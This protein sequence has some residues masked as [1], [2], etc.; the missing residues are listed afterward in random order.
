MRDLRPRS[1][2]Q[3]RRRGRCALKWDKAPCR[4]CGT[5]CGVMVGVQGQPGGRHPRRHQAEVN[6]GLNCVKGYFLSKIMYGARPAHQPLLRKKN[7]KYD[8]N[9]EFTPVSWD[10]AFDV[11]AEK[12]KAA[13]KKRADGGR[14]VR[15]RPVDDLGRLCRLEADARPAS[16]PTTSIPTR[17]TAWPRPSPA[18][19][20]PS[21]WT[22]RWAATTTSRPPTPSCCGARTWPRC[23]RSCGRASPTAGCPR[24]MCASPCSRPSST[25][26]STSPTSA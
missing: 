24:R 23:T 26:R 1:Q 7:G 16:A 18:S 20:A 4:F 13:L 12:F 11:M 10:E 17:A 6:R 2:R 9:G 25:A 22:S 19:C 3:A 15:L 14:H 8:K 5:G 21:A